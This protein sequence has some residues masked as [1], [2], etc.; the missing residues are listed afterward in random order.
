MRAQAEL[1]HEVP[2]LLRRLRHLDAGRQQ[3]LD[4]VA[5]R[6]VVQAHDALLVGCKKH[7]VQGTALILKRCLERPIMVNGTRLTIEAEVFVG[8]ADWSHL[9]RIC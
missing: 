8:E 5:V 4:E 2:L 9:R 3:C 7:A 6:P 1:G